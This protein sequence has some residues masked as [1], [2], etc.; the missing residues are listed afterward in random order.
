[1][2]DKQPAWGAKP[3]PKVPKEKSDKDYLVTLL[4]AIFLGTLGIHRFYVGKT[5]TGLLMMFTL[6]GIFIWAFID[7]IMVACGSF[8]DVDGKV[9]RS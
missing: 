9:I 3:K 5:G 6:G 1:M 7:M 2:T 8:T 4:L